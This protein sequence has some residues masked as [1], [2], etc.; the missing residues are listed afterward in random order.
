MKATISVVTP[1][2]ALGLALLVTMLLT[3]ADVP[4][5]H[6]GPPGQGAGGVVVAIEEPREGQT[7]AGE[8][9]V[10]GWAIDTRATDSTGVRST[11]GV[12][13]W[14]DRGGRSPIGVLLG[15]AVHGSERPDVAQR[16]GAQ[17]NR[18][19]FVFRWDACLVP[20]GRHSLQVFTESTATGAVEFGSQID[21]VV[22]P[23]PTAERPPAAVPGQPLRTNPAWQEILRRTSEL[24]GLAPRQDIYR[25]PLTRET[26][27][28][29]F[30]AEFAEYY[31]SRNVDTSRLML[32]AFGL[33]DPGFNLPEELRRLYGALPLGVFDV[34]HEMLFTQRDPPESPL[35]KVTMAHEITHALQHQHYDLRRLLPSSSAER[36]DDQSRNPDQLMAIRALVEGDA[37]L[38]Q[39][40]Y[41]ATSIHDPA[42]LQRLEQE[43]AQA[44]STIDFERLPFIVGQTMYFPYLWGPQFIHGVLGSG[45]L[46]TYG[47]YGPA[48]DRLFRRLPS[49]TSQLLHPERYVQRIEPVPVQMPSLAPIL[50]GE[51]VS[52]GEGPVGELNHR[53]ILENWLRQTDPERAA[54]ASSGWTGDRVAVFRRGDESGALVQDLVVVL[55]TRWETA[56]AAEAWAQT[57]ATIVPMLYRGLAAQ[58]GRGDDVLTYELGPGRLAW[59]MPLERAI[60]L[61]WTRQSSVIAIAPDLD[62]A[63]QLAEFAI[64][65]D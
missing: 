58:A 63:R 59:D 31:Q 32:V 48:V 5:L 21:I 20:T 53:L 30:E 38:T 23:C 56:T 37:I 18:S 65:G 25:A 29:R 52:L 62:L 26:F 36:R 1:R 50:G 42:E 19:G 10:R 24:R 39:R 43:E 45:P 57:Y 2:T 17:H 47:E 34:E 28:Q 3:P 44:S 41:Q 11:D 8:V 27:N 16:Y 15:A 14:L 7:V 35:A 60:A 12:Q 33:V 61:A 4:V 6:A 49:S 64:A 9:L 40:M 13:V 54:H 51:W 22:E 46:T 55:K